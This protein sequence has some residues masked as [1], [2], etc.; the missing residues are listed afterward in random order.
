MGDTDLLMAIRAI[1]S[2]LANRARPPERMHPDLS[3]EQ[4]LDILREMQPVGPF[5][6]QGMIEQTFGPPEDLDYL[7]DA[8][9][10]LRYPERYRS[11]SRMKHAAGTPDAI[12]FNPLEDVQVDNSWGDDREEPETSEQRKARRVARRRQRRRGE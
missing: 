12:P 5:G 8:E 6:P 7:F 4:L 1:T 2:V 10:N 3:N 11:Q 9:P